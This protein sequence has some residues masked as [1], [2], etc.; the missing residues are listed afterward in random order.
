MLWR[1]YPSLPYVREYL[2][3]LKMLKLFYLCNL[4]SYL[5]LSSLPLND[6]CFAFYPRFSMGRILVTV[7]AT[8]TGGW[9]RNT[10]FVRGTKYTISFVGFPDYCWLLHASKSKH[11]H[12]E[13]YTLL[14]HLIQNC[15]L[16]GI[17][18]NLLKLG[19]FSA[20][21]KSE[22]CREISTSIEEFYSEVDFQTTL[23]NSQSYFD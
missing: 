21:E 1:Y 4:A 11:N 7:A 20:L 9:T 17:L 6:F 2:P 5:Q 10:T 18:R 3:T 22:R 12:P 8:E 14:V 16:L 15:Q 19:N 13:A 23:P